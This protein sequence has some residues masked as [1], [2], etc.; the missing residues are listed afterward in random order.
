M[1]LH[2]GGS[3]PINFER[4]MYNS[5]RERLVSS[6]CASIECEKVRVANKVLK[7]YR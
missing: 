2:E 3:V 6:L 7:W 1:V 4:G 5:I